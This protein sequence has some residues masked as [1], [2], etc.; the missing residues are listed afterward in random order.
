MILLCLNSLF[1]WE[2]HIP[3]R[4]ISF[5]FYFLPFLPQT[6]HLFLDPM[7]SW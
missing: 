2:T 6:G 4:F 1:H 5:F 3:G 7:F